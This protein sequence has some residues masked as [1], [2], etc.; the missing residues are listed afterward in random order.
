MRIS[1][2][3]LSLTA[4]G[5]AALLS[6]CSLIGGQ[7]NTTPRDPTSSITASQTIDAFS[8]Q[9][10][11]CLD[12]PQDGTFSD[13]TVVGCN[14]AHDSEITNV[15]DMP[16]GTF[17]QDDIDTAGNQC[18]AAAQSYVGP[19][20]QTL[21][22]DWN[23]FSPTSDSW[24]QGDREIDCLVYTLSGNPDLTSSVKGQGN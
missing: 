7:N 19:N 5:A 20:Y 17:S 18:E 2:L 9:L 4:I 15:F 11:D 1:R 22:L 13:L 24:A 12:L 23:Y 8:V 10:G 21:G 6:S 14:Q 3:A 16:D